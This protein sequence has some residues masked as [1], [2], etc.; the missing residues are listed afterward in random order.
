MQELFASL[1]E[2]LNIKSYKDWAVFDQRLK[3][4]AFREGKARRV[5]ASRTVYGLDEE[6]YLNEISGELYF[7]PPDEKIRARWEPVDALAPEREEESQPSGLAAIPIR[8]M[9]SIQ[10]ESLKQMLTLLMAHGVAEVADRQKASSMK[11]LRLGIK[12]PSRK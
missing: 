1:A 10:K 7:C 3:T 4:L 9:N 5:S 8:Q 2:G 6:W 11:G 12:M